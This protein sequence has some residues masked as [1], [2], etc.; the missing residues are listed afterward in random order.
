MIIDKY[1]NYYPN[2]ILFKLL[3]YNL[4]ININLIQIKHN[5]I[6]IYILLFINKILMILDLNI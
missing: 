6:Y 2:F 5:Y 4:L 3:I 1:Y